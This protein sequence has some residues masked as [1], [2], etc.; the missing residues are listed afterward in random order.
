MILLLFELNYA[1]NSYVIY[2]DVANDENC[3][4]KLSKDGMAVG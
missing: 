3:I 1:L 2:T 4:Q